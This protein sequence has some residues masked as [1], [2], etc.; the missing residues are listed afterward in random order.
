[1][2]S[3][4]TTADGLTGRNVPL[5]AMP[6]N[7]AI[8]LRWAMASLFLDIIETLVL[9][10]IIFFDSWR[11]GL[12]E[13][14]GLL[15]YYWVVMIG[16]TIFQ[17]IGIGLVTQLGWYRIGGVLQII[18]S[19][20]QVIKVDGLIGVVGGMKAYRYGKAKAAGETVPQPNT[21]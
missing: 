3:Q 13:G 14:W 2:T 1:M 7:Q 6:F 20:T 19:T 16:A 4:T 17:A 18:A 12:G 8:G 9:A 10:E 11:S 21:Q 15:E 5:E